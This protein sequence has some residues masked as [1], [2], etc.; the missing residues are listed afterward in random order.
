MRKLRIMIS[1]IEKLLKSSI[2][3][4]VVSKIWERGFI[5]SMKNRVRLFANR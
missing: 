5:L 2:F 1:L 3:N 4:H